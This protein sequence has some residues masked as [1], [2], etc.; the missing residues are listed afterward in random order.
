L[1]T[2]KKDQYEYAVHCEVISR[3]ES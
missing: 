1:N 2:L 3:V